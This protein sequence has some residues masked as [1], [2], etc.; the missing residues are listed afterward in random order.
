MRL[1]ADVTGD[2]I[3]DLIGG[4]L[5]L[6]WTFAALTVFPGDGQGGVLS[7]IQHPQAIPYPGD[8]YPKA[9]LDLDGDGLTDVISTFSYG[10][11][12]AICIRIN[13]GGGSFGPPVY[14]PH[15]YNAP[16][17]LGACM[18]IHSCFETWIRTGRSISPT[19]PSTFLGR[20]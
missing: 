10:W 6:S 3:P 19:S 16:G 13:Q 12:F 18:P 15:G 4:Y 5:D 20:P 8:Y 7:P 17:I 1:A 14:L 9:A 11:S 2:G